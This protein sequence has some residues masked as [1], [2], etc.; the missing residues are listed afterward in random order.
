MYKYE[1]LDMS[2]LIYSNKYTAIVRKKPSVPMQW[3]H[4]NSLLKGRVLD[5]GCGRGFDVKYYK[6]DGYDPRW[7]VKLKKR[8]YDTITCNFVLNVVWPIEQFQIIDHIKHL[9]KKN[10]KAYFT[11][12]RDIKKGYMV[13]RGNYPQRIVELE[14]NSVCHKAGRF[15]IYE[16]QKNKK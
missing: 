16:Y 10:G 13:N 11:V 15:E 8:K 3:L 14:F 5:Y 6:I 2:K 1:P 7:N 9:L 4:N 12:R